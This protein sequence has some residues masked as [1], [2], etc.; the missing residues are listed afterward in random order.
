MQGT[1]ELGG[2]GGEK[3][4]VADRVVNITLTTI[5]DCRTRAVVTFNTSYILGSNLPRV[6]LG[7]IF[8][9]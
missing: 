9:E 2:V 1:A 7:H 5:T 6:V 4:V 3:R 8:C